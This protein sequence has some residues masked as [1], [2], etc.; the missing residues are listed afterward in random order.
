MPELKF[1]PEATSKSLPVK[2]FNVFSLFLWGKKF[3]HYPE[4]VHY[5]SCP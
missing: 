1:D 3:D 4:I 5:K 2:K